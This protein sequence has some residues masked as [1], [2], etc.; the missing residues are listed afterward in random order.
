MAH[1]SSKA[2]L[3]CEDYFQPPYA[4]PV[5]LFIDHVYI[6]IIPWAPNCFHQAGNRIQRW[7]THR[8]PERSSQEGEERI[9]DAT[10]S[11]L[12]RL[13]GSN[14]S[15]DVV[16][17]LV[18]GFP[19]ASLHKNEK[20][21]L[22][23]QQSVTWNVDSVKYLSE[24]IKHDVG[25]RGTR[26]GLFA[27]SKNRTWPDHSSINCGRGYSDDPIPYDTAYLEVI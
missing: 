22:P 8:R 20:D 24:G 11:A 25:G 1:K 2:F 13:H 21:Q 10:G 12:H 26:S 15:T 14:P 19:E 6:W 23:I 18:E 4:L 27:T 16:K 5:L 7:E 3:F 17:E 9:S